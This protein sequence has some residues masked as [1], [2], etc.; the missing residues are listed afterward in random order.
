M[1]TYDVANGTRFKW[2]EQLTEIKWDV[3]DSVNY[4]TKI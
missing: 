2:D 3:T 4:M 1:R